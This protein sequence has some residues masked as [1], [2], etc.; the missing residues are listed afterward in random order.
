MEVNLAVDYDVV[1][2]KLVDRVGKT[3]V[4]IVDGIPRFG[5]ADTFSLQWNTFRFTQLDSK[6]GRKISFQRFWEGTKWKPKDLYGKQILEAGSGAG[7][8]TE[9]MLDAGAKA[10]TF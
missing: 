10:A 5:Y 2:G 4:M 7:R 8:F 9:V 1:S 3:D 6:P